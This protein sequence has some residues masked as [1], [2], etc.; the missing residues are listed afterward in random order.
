MPDLHVD[1][2]IG[3]DDEAKYGFALIFSA[4]SCLLYVSNRLDVGR[5]FIGMVV[6]GGEEE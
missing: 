6:D 1:V 4:S 3:K 2:G 5:V